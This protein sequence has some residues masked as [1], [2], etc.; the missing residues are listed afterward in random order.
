MGR[1]ESGLRWGH[2]R[3]AEWDGESGVLRQQGTANW[4]E[5]AK[6]HGETGRHEATG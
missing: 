1:R 3:E 5:L 4:L 2:R 6:P